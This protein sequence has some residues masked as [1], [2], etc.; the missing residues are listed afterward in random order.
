MRVRWDSQGKHLGYQSQAIWGP[1]LQIA[2]KELGH[3]H[4]YKLIP[5]GYR[6]FGVGYREMAGTCE[7][8]S[9][10]SGEDCS[11]TIDVC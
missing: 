2:V 10:V 3:R 4:M 7:R 9:P 8:A 1:M 6:I 11:Q 5:R